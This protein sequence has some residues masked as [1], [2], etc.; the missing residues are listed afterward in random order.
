[1]V[2]GVWAGRV[3]AN[4]GRHARTEPYRGRHRKPAAHLGL[5]TG[6][7]V[8][9]TLACAAL[10]VCLPQPG[11]AGHAGTVAAHTTAAHTTAAHTTAARRAAAAMPSAVR[12][13]RSTRLG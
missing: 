3:L 6:A 5:G 7:R 8:A 10:F 9:I 2:Q 12:L 4:G 1:V 13:I 11:W